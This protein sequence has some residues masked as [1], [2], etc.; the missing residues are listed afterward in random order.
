MNKLYTDI[1]VSKNK[2]TRHFNCKKDSGEF[3][4]HRDLKDRK[5][6]VL[7]G[8]G[9]KFQF[10]DELPFVININDILFIPQMKYHRI[11]PGFTD[12]SIEIEEE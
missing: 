12:L 10:D 6:R 5:V 2:K 9:W 7:A 4:W 11:L 3:V 1:P 8:V